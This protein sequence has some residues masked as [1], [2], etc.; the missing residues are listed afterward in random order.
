VVLHEDADD[1]IFVE[2]FRYEAGKIVGAR[3]GKRTENGL[4]QERVIF[5]ILSPK[6]GR[7]F[8]KAVE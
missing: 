3:F 5:Q 7:I 2:W 6:P 1:S 4:A 8:P